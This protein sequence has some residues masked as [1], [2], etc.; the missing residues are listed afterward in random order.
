MERVLDATAQT[1]QALGAVRAKRA[2]FDRYRGAALNDRQLDV[3]NRLF[4]PFDGKLTRQKYVRLVGK[5]VV[6][7]TSQRQPISEDTALRDLEGLVAAGMLV[8]EGAGRGVHY[9]VQL[10]RDLELSLIHI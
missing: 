5:R 4:E 9:R 7:N 8:R 1:Q 2:Y 6:E 3:L 10:P